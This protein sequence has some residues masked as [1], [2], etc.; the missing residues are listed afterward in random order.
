MLVMGGALLMGAAKKAPRFDTDGAL[1]QPKGYRTWIFVGAPITPNSLNPPAAPFP[2]FHNVYM[3]PED[4]AHYQQ[5]GTFRDGTILIK[6]LL[7][8]GATQA[9]SGNGFFQGEYVGLEAAVKDSKRFSNE[10]GYWAYCTFSHESP[11]YPTTA[12][13]QPVGA[14][15]ACHQAN[16]AQDWVFTQYYP[17]LRAAKP[18]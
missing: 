14:C 10:P 3:H 15:N 11:P 9:A 13:Q 16:A 4:Y 5:T 2:E 1:I 12:M 18:K 17:V 6:E 7:S 8:V